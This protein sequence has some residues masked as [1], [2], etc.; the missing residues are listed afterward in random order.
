MRKSGHS[1]ISKQCG[2]LKLFYQ[3]SKRGRAEENWLFQNCVNASFAKT[4]E[5]NV[6]A[7]SA[8][9][10]QSAFFLTAGLRSICEDLILLRYLGALSEDNRNRFI[11]LSMQHEVLANLKDQKVFFS[12]NRP[13]QIVLD[14]PNDFEVQIAKAVANLQ[15]FWKERGWNLG[16]KQTMPQIRQLAERRGVET[17]YDFIYRLTCDV[18]HFNPQ[19]LLRSG[20]GKLPDVEFSTRHFEPYY[21]DFAVIYGSL[22]FCL[23]FQLLKR[24][25]KPDRKTMKT[26]KRIRKMLDAVNR[27]PELVTFEEMNVRPPWHGSPI[28]QVLHRVIAERDNPRKRK[29]LLR[30]R[31][32]TVSSSQKK[33]SHPSGIQPKK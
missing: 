32:R 15:T 23:Y 17:L 8:T 24:F 6:L 9:K 31:R 13:F 27:W 11:H 25:L 20:W 19:V 2:K 5:F 4:Y 16:G 14:A 12:E 28:L 21:Q 26:V 30:L 10:K 33:P 7:N 22:L 29:I 1:D 3:K 18:V